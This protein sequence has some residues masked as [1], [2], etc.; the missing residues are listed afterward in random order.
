M[1]ETVDVAIIGA[2]LS[3][4]SA[5]VHLYEAGK[6]VKIF[7]ANDFIGGKVSTDYVDG[8]TL[9]K[10]FQLFLT[11]YPE[12]KAQLD[13]EKLQ[14]HTFNQGVDIF[15]KGKMTRLSPLNG[16]LL[17]AIKLIFSPVAGFKDAWTFSKL[18]RRLRKSTAQQT[19]YN[20]HENALA[21]LENEGFSERFINT[22]FKPYIG[23]LLLDKSLL[24]SGVVIDFLLKMLLS[25][26]MAL[27]EKGM[28]AIPEQLA[29][30]L[31]KESVVFNHRVNKI[32]HDNE[33]VFENGEKFKG[34]NILL[35]TDPWSAAKI[36]DLSLPPPGHGV[37]CAYFSAEKSP[38][39]EPFLLLNGEDRGPITQLAVLSDVAPSYAP[40]GASLISATILDN[41]LQLSD[42]N[43]QN[44][45]KEQLK[46]WFGS[47]VEG[48]NLLKLYRISNAQPSIYPD[49]LWHTPFHYKVRD[50]VYACGDY[51][52]APTINSALKTGRRASEEILA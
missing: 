16:D 13:L 11:S 37:A 22:F 10:G 25:G 5:A 49:R 21:C 15:A 32:S 28:S 34:N 20:D 38:L 6:S 36:L 44:A 50:N 41:N 39:Q 46:K 43:L 3:G 40:P 52:E 7:E 17:S 47:Q 42:E 26:Q 45:S 2:G 33:L 19:L 9:D 14:L 35:A 30:K 1:E 48:W 12:C 23:G 24:S 18:N 8:F 27:P 29:A 51:L 31:P 4:L